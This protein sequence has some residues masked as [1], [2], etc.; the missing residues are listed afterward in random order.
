MNKLTILLSALIV[1]LTV[2]SCKGVTDESELIGFGSDT[3]EL[4]VKEVSFGKEGGILELQTASDSWWLN[5]LSRNA[6]LLTKEDNLTI[7]EDV[8]NKRIGYKCDFCEVS[9]IGNML[10]IKMYPKA[11]D[12]MVVYDLVLQDGDFFAYLK[13]IHK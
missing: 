1:A 2:S 11:S 10:Q 6:R 13:V 3:I 12:E 5:S 7:V 9:K 4:D 8:R